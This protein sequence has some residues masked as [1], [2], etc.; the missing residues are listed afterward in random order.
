MEGIYNIAID[1]QDEGRF[2]TAG[3]D[4]NIQLWRLNEEGKRELVKTISAGDT[5]ISQV[6]FSPDGKLLAAANWNRTIGL[7]NTITGRSI[8]TLTGHQ[9]GINSIAFSSNHQSAN[10]YFLV[11][12]SEDKT[13]KLWQISDNK[14]SLLHTLTGHQEGIKTVAISPDGKLIASGSYDKTIKLWNWD[15]K[16]KQTLTG[17]N[18]A[19]TALAFSADGR[20]LA[21]GSADNT[22]NLWQINNHLA[23]LSKTLTGHQAGVTSLAYGGDSNFDW[24]ASA[25]SDRTI[26]LWNPDRGTLLKTLQGHSSQINSIALFDRGKSLLSADEQ[27]GLYWWDLDLDSLLAYSCKRLENYLQYDLTLSQRD[28]SICN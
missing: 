12:G 8:A 21:S 15:G 3:W 28:R 19:I 2:A 11:S 26:K 20:T 13:V 9:D 10:S 17:H 7:W 5:A 23:K 16:F 25:S 4:G 6:A 24:L 1:P 14:T 18:L 27:Q 22:I